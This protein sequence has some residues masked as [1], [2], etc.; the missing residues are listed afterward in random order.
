MKAQ[1][2]KNDL[3]FSVRP[4]L[5]P[6]SDDRECSCT[7]MKT[8]TKSGQAR[9][10]LDGAQRG[11]AIN[12][13]GCGRRRVAGKKKAARGRPRSGFVML[14]GDVSG[15]GVGLESDHLFTNPVVNAGHH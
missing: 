11:V 6:D 3:K 9:R 14:G 12:F 8:T 13:N 10:G 4:P 15:K 1:G 2:S 7:C 5:A